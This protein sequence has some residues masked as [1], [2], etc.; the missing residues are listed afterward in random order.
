MR[1]LL[2][3]ER[4]AYGAIY[5]KTTNNWIGVVEMITSTACGGIIF[6]LIGGQPMVIYGGTGTTLAFVEIIYKM[7][8]T[9]DVPFLT[10]NSWIG[11]CEL[12]Q[13]TIMRNSRYMF[14]TFCIP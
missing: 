8:V 4:L 1:I 14:L 12:T 6:A 5:A 7:S 10:F 9:M 3:S 11:I 2:P 13:C